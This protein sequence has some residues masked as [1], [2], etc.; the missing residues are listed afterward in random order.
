MVSVPVHK[1]DS[2]I[3][4]FHSGAHQINI[5]AADYAVI[6]KVMAEGYV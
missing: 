6:R 3:A 2:L 4:S 5:P 1:V